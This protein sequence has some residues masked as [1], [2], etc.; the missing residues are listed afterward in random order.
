MYEN[1]NTKGL[2][3]HFPLCMLRLLIKLC[4]LFLTPIMSCSIPRIVM[5]YVP[6]AL[7]SKFFSCIP[8]LYVQTCYMHNNV[9]NN[10]ERGGDSVL[11][12]SF[13]YTIQIY[14]LNYS[15]DIDN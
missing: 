10:T 8:L 1:W 14:T 6:F 12:D 3:F 2:H 7:V 11:S 15:S 13:Q 4:H 9:G 5:M